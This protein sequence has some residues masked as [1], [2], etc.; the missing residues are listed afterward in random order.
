MNIR[1]CSALV[2]LCTAAAL[3]SGCIVIHDDAAAS[4]KR[5]YPLP[6]HVTATATATS[7]PTGITIPP[8]AAARASENAREPEA[9]ISNEVTEDT[10]VWGFPVEIPGW[11]TTVAGDNGRIQYINEN[12]CL[13]TATQNPVLYPDSPSRHADLSD[14][15]Q[16]AKELEKQHHTR[17]EVFM[18]SLQVDKHIYSAES[19]VPVEMLEL[20]VGYTDFNDLSFISRTS[21]R[22]FTKSRPP[23][24]LV[25]EYVC[26][27]SAYNASDFY[28][29]TEDFSLY[30]VRHPRLT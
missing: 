16:Y 17:G 15:T 20:F 19:G 12:G 9:S 24:L 26:P 25:R 22:M 7:T 11:F 1:Y 29:D 30:H 6:P 10:V 21:V 14:S 4:G 18:S 28:A 5:R 8:S 27:Q 3:L 13:L 23:Q 2:A